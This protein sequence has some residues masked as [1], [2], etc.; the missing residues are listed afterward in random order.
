LVDALNTLSGGPHAGFRAN[1]AK[2]ILVEGTFTPAPTAPELSEAPHLAATVP[3]LVRFSDPTGVP[4]LP[5]TDPNAS[6]HGMAI[7][8][9]RPAEVSRTS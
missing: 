2:G 8:S 4:N 1:H 3:V 9:N 7:V 6:P 5:D